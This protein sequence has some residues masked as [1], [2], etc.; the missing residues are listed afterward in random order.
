MKIIDC[1]AN[2]GWDANNIRKNLF[3]TGQTYLQLLNKMQNFQV[4][5]SICMP[6]P[7]PNGRFS[8]KA[9]W[10]DIENN[11]I[12]TSSRFSNKLIPFAA[13][14]PGDK[15]SV[16]QIKSLASLEIIKGIKFSHQIPMGFDIDSLIGNPLM[17]IASDHNL[18][19]LIHVGTGKEKGANHVHTTLDYGLKV[20]KKYPDQTFIFCHLGRLHRLIGEALQMEN[21][22]MDTSGLAMHTSWKQFLAK[23]FFE[24]LSKSTPQQV[25]E[26]LCDWGY[27]DKV[28]FG[29][30]EPYT[31]YSSQL[32]QITGADITLKAKR[33]LLSENVVKVVGI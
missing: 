20:A 2:L 15:L 21:V 27:D 8:L 5:K 28:L 17:K 11:Y 10:Y 16:G 22:Y 14:N 7:I 1:H 12:L 31:H 29:S 25:I 4:N 3:P 32:A 9:P 23:D 13:V 18:P 24:P 26:S 19:L 30:D 6:F 33:K